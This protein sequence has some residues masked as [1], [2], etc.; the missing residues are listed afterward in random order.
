[1]VHSNSVMA[2]DASGLFTITPPPRGPSVPFLSCLGSGVHTVQDC[3]NCCEKDQFPALTDNELAQCKTDCRIWMDNS[4]TQC[5][6]YLD[7]LSDL[8]YEDCSVSGPGGD[9]LAC[10]A[11][12]AERDGTK[13]DNG[14]LYNQCV[15][16][17]QPSCD[18]P[19]AKAREACIAGIATK[20]DKC[21]SKC[22]KKAVVP[23]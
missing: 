18:N 17:S 2:T 1:Y 21:V 4:P 5:H 7:P 15:C 20:L 3:D 12:N 9:C 23:D 14:Y 10:C 11:R 8:K 16:A 6:A 22:G 19:P 13:C